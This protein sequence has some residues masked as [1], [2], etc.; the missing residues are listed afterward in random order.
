MSRYQLSDKD[1]AGAIKELSEQQRLH[2]GA[3][4][5][6]AGL[7]GYSSPATAE[8][9]DTAATEV[10]R[11]TLTHGG[12]FRPAPADL[13]TSGSHEDE[14]VRLTASAPELFYPRSA[15]RRSAAAR[16]RQ[17]SQTLALS[18]TTASPAPGQLISRY[19][20]P[21]TYGGQPVMDTP[22]NRIA[23]GRVLAPMV[24]DTT[25]DPSS[26]DPSVV[27]TLAS[28]GYGLGVSPDSSP[29]PRP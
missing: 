8:M 13:S 1:V 14:V 18:R 2:A 24:V 10:E 26:V 5:Q 4:A 16:T 20:L 27:Q 7:V 11:I 19:G 22:E 12:M 25:D 6:L 3:I 21:V 29:G 17:A 23:F 15:R 28:R 9:S